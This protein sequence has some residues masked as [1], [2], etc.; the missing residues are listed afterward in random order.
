MTCLT[1]FLLNFIQCHYIFY[2]FTFIY[3]DIGKRTIKF[4]IYLKI[5]VYF[6]NLI[7][8]ALIVYC[9]LEALNLTT[10]YFVNELIMQLSYNIIYLAHMFMFVGLIWMRIKEEIFLKKWFKIILPL[11]TTYFDIHSQSLTDKTAERFQIFNV[12]ILFIQ[13]Y[14][15]LYK[16]ALELMNKSW[17][18]LLETCVFNLFSLM[19]NYIMIHHIFILCYI[20]NCFTKLNNELRIGEIHEA[21]AKIY[22]RISLLMR[23]VN[24]INGP[25][26][27]LVLFCQL[28][29][30]S[31]YIQMMFE[32][33]ATS[34][35]FF[36]MDLVMPFIIATIFLNIFLYFLICDQLYNT[37]KETGDI[38]LL[39]DAS[40]EN[41][42]P[43]I[44][45]ASI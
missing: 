37:L 30:I 36:I 6:L 41:Q 9:F 1:N 22:L 13:G 15:V 18:T 33:F 23:E 42:V 5:Y 29:Q 4:P 40:K 10:K 35:Y 45:F 26:I 44:Y 28:M 21:F 8:A 31:I 20:K 11:Q 24:I 7:Y 25:L 43:E 12:L 38:L 16:I 39:Y 14:Y 32:L 17:I 3:I 27:F 34:G 2:G 19:E